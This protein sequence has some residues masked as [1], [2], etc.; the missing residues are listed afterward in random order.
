MSSKVLLIH[1]FFKNVYN[2]RALNQLFLYYIV[3]DYKIKL[4]QVNSL[5]YSLLYQITIKKL[6]IIKE[7]LLKNLYKRFIIFNSSFFAFSVLFITKLN[8]SLYFC[9]NY[10]KLNSLIKK[11]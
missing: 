1:V 10:Y 6:L 4:I 5:N 2:K 3:I 8:S 9:I 11:D 7:Y